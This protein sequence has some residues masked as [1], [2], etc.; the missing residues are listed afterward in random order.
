MPIIRLAGLFAAI[1]STYA[2]AQNPWAEI[3]T[4][5]HGPARVIGKYSA[6]CIAG[7]VSLPLDGPG[8][9]V[10]RPSRNRYWGHPNLIDFAQNTTHQLSEHGI[11]MLVADLAQ[12]R[13]GPIPGDHASHNVGLDMDFWFVQDPR[14]L[15]RPL[16]SEERENMQQLELADLEENRLHTSRW[17]WRYESMLKIA[18]SWSQVERIF[19]H[20]TIKK[21]LCEDPQ[22]HEDWL[23]KIRPWWGHNAH[24]H[25]R[26]ACP[27][28][29]PDCIPQA[30]QETIACDET[31]DW[32]F[33]DEWREEWERRKREYESETS[34]TET[35]PQLP[36][37][38][39]SVLRW[40]V[41]KG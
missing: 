26:L 30:P 12:P 10:I 19:V 11:V 38:C 22:N 7:A 41:L 16:T 3:Q 13:G 17:N 9:Q 23:R 39:E 5:T 40:P 15:T 29:S 18:A 4:P 24:F 36:A 27:N 2:F 31:L 28:E 20:P 33:S 37:A 6:G 8:Y 14:A 34:P 25:V 21:K 35:L 1:F 32:W